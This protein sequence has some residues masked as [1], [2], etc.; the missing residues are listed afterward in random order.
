MEI[1]KMREFIIKK[2]EDLGY[3]EPSTNDYNYVVIDVHTN[4]FKES[5][6]CKTTTQGIHQVRVH[7]EEDKI[8]TFYDDSGPDVMP[9]DTIQA[10][11]DNIDQFIQQL[12]I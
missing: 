10:T 6:K 7:V 5:L 4:G 11:V 1:D 2:I 3:A 8:V 9:V 12:S